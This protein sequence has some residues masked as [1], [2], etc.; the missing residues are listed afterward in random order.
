MLIQYSSRGVNKEHALDS[1]NVVEV[2]VGRSLLMTLGGENSKVY[3][4]GIKASDGEGDGEKKGE[5]S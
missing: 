3:G 1:G 2:I 4:A 5:S